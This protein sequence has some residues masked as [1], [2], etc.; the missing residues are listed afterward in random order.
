MSD[1]LPPRPPGRAVPAQGISD[2]QVREAPGAML[3]AVRAPAPPP[4]HRAGVVDPAFWLVRAERPRAS[5]LDWGEGCSVHAESALVHRRVPPPH[6]VVH[7]SQIHNPA[8]ALRKS[9]W[10]NSFLWSQEDFSGGCQRPWW[11]SAVTT[12]G[13]AEGR[14]GGGRGLLLGASSSSSG[15]GCGARDLVPCCG[16]SESLERLTEAH[17]ISSPS[18]GIVLS[19]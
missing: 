7:L 12:V 8:C 16:F 3:L 15:R 10:N 2:T 4:T 17:N 6:T 1:S 9:C 14:G 19:E 11:D 13:K 5:L 18:F